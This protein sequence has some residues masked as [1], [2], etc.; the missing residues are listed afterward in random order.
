MLDTSAPA[1][2]DRCTSNEG[3]HG[4]TTIYNDPWQPG[5]RA[6]SDGHVYD[7]ILTVVRDLST[8]IGTIREQVRVDLID[9]LARYREDTARTTLGLAQRITWIE[10][11]QITEGRERLLRQQLL[12][13]RQRWLYR[14]LIILLVFMFLLVIGVIAIA[15]LLWRMWK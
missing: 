14:M 15:I 10:A 7:S 13:L 9:Y 4:N 1:Y 12:D 5:A 3:T 11:Q 2:A 6:M 8:Q